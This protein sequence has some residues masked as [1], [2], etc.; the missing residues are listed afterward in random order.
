MGLG[1]AHN[2]L[3]QY[4]KAIAFSKQSINVSESI[5]Y[6]IR[7]LPQDSQ[8]AYVKSI[9]ETYTFLAKL[10]KDQGRSTEAQAVLTLLDRV[11]PPTPTGFPSLPPSSKSSPNLPSSLSFSRSCHSIS[12]IDLS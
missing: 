2:S 4:E 8:K 3:S 9:A 5:R 6:G 7:Q 10:L 1:L 12:P 11:P